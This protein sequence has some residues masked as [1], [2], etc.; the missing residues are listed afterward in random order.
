MCA[1]RHAGA[2]VHKHRKGTDGASGAKRPQG[3]NYR[4][5]PP[6]QSDAL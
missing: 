2:G 1:W 5:F 4:T 3:M 6:P